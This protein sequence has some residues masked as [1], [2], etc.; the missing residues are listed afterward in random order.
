MK[1]QIVFILL[2]VGSIVFSCKKK[3]T[4]TEPITNPS[5]NT[6]APAGSYYGFF[7]LEKYCSWYSGIVSY[8]TNP[9]QCKMQLY[10]TPVNDYASWQAAN[11]GTIKVNNH[12]LEYTIINIYQDSSSLPNYASQRAISLTSTV[13][14]SFTTSVADT[15]PT[16]APSNAI[17]INDT[18]KLNTGITIPLTNLTYYDN[19]YCIISTNPFT[20]SNFAISKTVN[21]GI[22]QIV[23]TPTDLNIFAIGQQLKCRLILRKYSTQTFNGKTFRFECWSYNDFYMV[24]Q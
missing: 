10:S 23:F 24:A 5:P 17:L 11:L 13:L 16:Y 4:T 19:V 22:N 18:L 8:P 9:Y 2:V 15:F 14:P 21:V 6:T 7:S 20:S 1:K 12:V 3:E